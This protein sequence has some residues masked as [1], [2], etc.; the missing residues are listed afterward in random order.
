MKTEFPFVY[1]S[2]LENSDHKSTWCCYDS[3]TDRFIGKVEHHL[4]AKGHC[5]FPD[6]TLPYSHGMLNDISNFI[7]ILD[8]S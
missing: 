3:F 1:F 5:Y 6:T 8:N 7:I 2:N 4:P